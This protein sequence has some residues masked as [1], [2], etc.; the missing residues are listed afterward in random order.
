VSAATLP[1]T[2]PG[3]LRRG[4]PVVVD[5]FMCG[6]IWATGA[7]V[8]PEALVTCA[9]GVV[10]RPLTALPLDLTDPTGMDHAARWLAGKVG[11]T[12]GATAPGWFRLTEPQ[13]VWWLDC[14]TGTD[15]DNAQ[16]AAFHDSDKVNARV[17]FPLARVPGI[18][19]LTNPAEAL[20]LACLAVSR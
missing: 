11:L 7:D 15:A 16:R 17:P 18:S 12:V 19:A 3:L 10:R 4:S 5:D 8:H 13:P 2:L 6:T 14:I 1:G 20:A 9:L